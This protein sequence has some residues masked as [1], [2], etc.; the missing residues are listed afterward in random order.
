MV[1][2]RG[3]TYGFEAV[4]ER[5]KW[6]LLGLLLVLVALAF[7]FVRNKVKGSQE[8]FKEL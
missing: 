6:F 5:Y 8:T 1:T 3:D 2:Y 4:Y 7:V